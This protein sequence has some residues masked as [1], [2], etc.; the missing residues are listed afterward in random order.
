MK[1]YYDDEKHQ[2]FVNGELKPN[3]TDIASPISFERLNALQ[4]VL[5]ERARQRGSRCHELFEEYLLM[6]DLDIN[7]IE[8]EYIP[9]V[10]QFILWA[11]TYRP[12]VMYTEKKM[13]SNDFCGTCDLIC[14]IDKKILLVD[15]KVTSAI[16]KKSLSVQLEGY[17][18]LCKKYKIKIDDCYYLH[19]KK[20]GYVFKPIK[21]NDRWFDIL[22]E[23][24]KFMKEKY[25]GK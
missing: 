11:K 5:L 21:R 23:H 6:G 3:V 25:D 24:N 19:I 20:D 22:L 9:Y 18:R 17:Y 2:Y 14:A 13:F 7:E 12:K 8:M 15:Y 10:Q 16:D 1:T 4:Q